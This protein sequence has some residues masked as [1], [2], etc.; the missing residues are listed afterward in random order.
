MNSPEP[1]AKPI[2]GKAI[3]LVAVGIVALTVLAVGL[4]WW[5]A[6]SGL[7]GEKLV[8]ARFEALRIG[9]S[10]GIGG[11]GVFALYLSWRR[12]RTTEQD[13]DNRERALAHQ[14]DVAADAKAHQ[15]RM[16]A[17]TEKDGVERRITDLYTKAADQLG[18]DKAPV[19][20]AGLYALERLAQ[21]NPGHRQTVVN[22][23]CAYLRMPFDPPEDTTPA[24]PA[25]LPEHRSRLQEREV[26]RAVQRI[27]LLH[28][29]PEL[30]EF[31][32]D[33]DLGLTGAVL[34]DF[35]L[36]RCR[37]RSSTFAMAS[38]QYRANF[39]G[40]RFDGYAWFRGTTFTGQ[41]WFQ[42]AEFGGHANFNEVTFQ[43]EA[44]FRDASFRHT[45]TWR[46]AS[47]SRGVPAEVTEVAGG[48]ADVTTA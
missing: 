25:A 19:R 41:A 22:V 45:S 14:R 10:I 12:Q 29:R 9:L 3:A 32:P 39:S 24:D 15:D 37:I 47:F 36:S 2:S 17:I 8:T 34:I 40:T 46:D 30:A 6:T 21:D 44:R 5:P 26:R 23:Y 18:S 28:L 27:L 35:D 33:M 31:W 42:G 1:R 38:F 7:T 48:V 4:L 43:D 20:M 11:G 16:A 13:L